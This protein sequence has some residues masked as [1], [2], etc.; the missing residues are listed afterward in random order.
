MSPLG[1]SSPVQP[2]RSQNA[3]LR[4]YSC[5]RP[6]PRTRLLGHSSPGVRLPSTVCPEAPRSRRRP[7]GLSS[8]ATL[9]GFLAPTA[10]T[11]NKSSRLD[12][13]RWLPSSTGR[14][15]R[16]F[17]SPCKHGQVIGP[18]IRWWFPTHQLRSRSQAFPT[19]QRPSSSRLRPT[20]FRWV[21]LMGLRPPGG[22]TFHEAPTARRRRHALL[23]FFPA[24]A[25][26]LS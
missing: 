12:Q 5:R 4:R 6:C 2:L 10:H 8:K 1:C 19:S 3:W 14:A 21:A 7:Q 9:L 26:P 16:P 24:G 18:G 25:L 17:P 13:L 15:P 23:T 22:Y 20:I 11:G